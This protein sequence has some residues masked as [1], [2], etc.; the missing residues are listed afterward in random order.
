M[1]INRSNF[2]LER[3]M[4]SQQPFEEDSYGG[5]NLGSWPPPG[6]EDFGDF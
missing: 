6:T 2:F 5:V 4:D 3:L 1:G